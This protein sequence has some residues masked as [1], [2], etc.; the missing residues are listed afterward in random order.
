MFLVCL[1]SYSLILTL[2]V[3]WSCVESCQVVLALP[4]FWFQGWGVK[5]APNM[6]TRILWLKRTFK[7]SEVT[8]MLHP[9]SSE[10]KSLWPQKLE[11]R[12]GVGGR[13]LATS[14]AKNTVQ[15]TRKIPCTFFFA[16][17]LSCRCWVCDTWI[18]PSPKEF[19]HMCTPAM[20]LSC[21]V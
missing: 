11:V 13:G 12:N 1:F 21:T 20:N 9:K 14:R 16:C 10:G 15:S 6:A 19:D 4:V 18:H 3:L 2:Y 5:E 8:K 17:C 7:E